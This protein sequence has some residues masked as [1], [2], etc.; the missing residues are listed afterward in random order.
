MITA[1]PSVLRYGAN[2]FS[3]AAQEMQRNSVRMEQMTLYVRQGQ[4]GWLGD[5]SQAF[6]L[7]GEQLANDIKKASLAFESIASALI[8]FANKMDH[9]LDLRRH[10]DRLDQQAFEYG[11]DTLD[12]IQ[13]RQSLRHK[14]AQL[15]HQ[16]DSEASIADMQASTEFQMIA[17]NIPS[18]LMPIESGSSGSLNDLP[19]QWR[20]YYSRHP[21][22]LEEEGS[23][24]KLTMGSYKPIDNEEQKR[25]DLAMRALIEYNKQQQSPWLPDADREEAAVIFCEQAYSTLSANELEDEVSRILLEEAENQEWQD[26]IQVGVYGREL[27]QQPGYFAFAMKEYYKNEGPTGGMHGVLINMGKTKQLEYK[28]TL[29]LNKDEQPEKKVTTI[30]EKVHDTGSEVTRNPKYYTAEGEIIWPPNRGFL[31]E[32]QKITLESRTRIDRYGYE[33]GTF[34][35]PEGIPYGMRALAPGTDKKPYTVYE[36]VKPVEV[37]AGKIAPWFDEPGMGVQYEFS[38]PIKDLIKD[39]ILRRVEQ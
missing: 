34:V 5:G 16:A 38:R 10:A 23:A 17:K 7:K 27:I 11:D 33:G 9:V 8:R 31:D 2:R 20:D 19:K 37:Q 24:N 26:K 6:Q 13:T 32:P 4:D 18:S 3:A 21:E 28:E 39:G 14:A 25:H 30:E 29:K 36:V 15:R 1:E 22:L 12:S 35:S